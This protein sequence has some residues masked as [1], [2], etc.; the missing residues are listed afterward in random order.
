MA[1]SENS[2][3]SS[4]GGTDHVEA[5]VFD[6]DNT[7]YPASCTL[8]PQI[9][10]RMRAFIAER[11]GLPL[12]EAF[13]LQKRYYREYGTTLR[14]LMLVHG[15]EPTA[16]LDY[17]H[18]IDCSVLTPC[19]RLD[20]ALGRLPGR[21]MVFT[22]GS[23]RHAVNVLGR[24]GIARHFDGIFDIGAADYIPKPQPATYDLMARR[25]G[26]D[27]R[28]AAMFEDIHAN[29]RPAAAIGMTTVWVNDPHAE[30]GLPT[31]GE[32]MSHVHHETADLAGWLDAR[33]PAVY[34]PSNE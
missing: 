26:V 31:P 15:V 23:E 21:K 30:W 2:T 24:L 1:P 32:D 34:C 20:A 14:G 7:L 17:V 10:V 12:D 6:L 4:L 18:E 16:F 3:E 33:H 13:R 5:W 27:P 22:N 8:F 25:H 11:L 19:G 9:D 28:R 29:L